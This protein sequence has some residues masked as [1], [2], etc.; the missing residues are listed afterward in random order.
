[1]NS[2]SS[3]TIK[4]SQ[5]KTIGLYVSPKGVELRAPFDAPDSYINQFIQQKQSWIEKQLKKTEEKRSQIYQLAD[6]AIIPIIGFDKVIYIAEGR[7]NRV[8][9]FDKHLDITVTRK[10]D[11]RIENAF[12]TFLISKAEEI[13]PTLVD[14]YVTQLSP[15]KSVK[16]IQY[17]R[18]KSKWGHCTHDGKLQFNW[19]IMLAPLKVIRS[20]VAHEVCHLIHLNHSKDFWALVQQ[21]DP[22]Y[23]LAKHW[24]NTHGY[25]LSL[26]D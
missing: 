21:I 23:L 3:V 12:R 5:R 26:F 18:T 25:K 14:E 7:R 13:I 24:L 11:Q 6:G 16:A 8:Q 20:L 1:M 2:A 17:R 19:L 22:D 4:R 9:E 15:K 10:D